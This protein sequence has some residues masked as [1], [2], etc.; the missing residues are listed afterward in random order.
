VS[1]HF[2]KYQK[3]YGE[4]GKLSAQHTHTQ[5]NNELCT[6]NLHY[7]FRIRQR[8][9]YFLIRSFASIQTLSRLCL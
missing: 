3:A 6:N 1:Y 7:A 4:I 2:N 9:Q 5:A 8:P